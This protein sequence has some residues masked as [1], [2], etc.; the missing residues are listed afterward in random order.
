MQLDMATYIYLSISMESY[1]TS[2]FY[3]VT[4]VKTDTYWNMNSRIYHNLSKFYIYIK[5]WHIYGV[6]YGLMPPNYSLFYLI[7]L[8]PSH[9]QLTAHFW[10]NG[11]YWVCQFVH[12]LMTVYQQE[13]SCGQMRHTYIMYGKRERTGQEAVAAYFMILHWHLPQKTAK[14]YKKK[15]TI[16]RTWDCELATSWIHI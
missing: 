7:D 13:Y 14:N 2:K 9:W 16:T 5:V 15:F 4:L 6:Y 8:H 1:L 11:T 12:S 10:D 3:H